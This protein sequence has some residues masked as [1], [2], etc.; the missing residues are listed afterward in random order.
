MKWYDI[1][2][3]RPKIGEWVFVW[4]KIG[5]KQILIKYFGSEEHWNRTKDESP[6]PIWAYPNNKEEDNLV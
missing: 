2:E 4:D 6:Y 5:Q 3:K 1:S